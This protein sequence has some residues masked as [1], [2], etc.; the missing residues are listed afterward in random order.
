MDEEIKS[1]HKNQIWE[2]VQLSKGKKAI[3]CKWVFA[4]KEDTPRV[5]FKAR[6]VAK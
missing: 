3:G 2:L 4:K 5:R 1:L 6:L